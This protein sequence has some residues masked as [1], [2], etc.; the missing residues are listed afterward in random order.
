MLLSHCPLSIVSSSSS[1]SLF[2][3]APSWRTKGPWEHLPLMAPTAS[4]IDEMDRH[5]LGSTG[6]LLSSV[7]LSPYMYNSD[8]AVLQWSV[9]SSF[10]GRCL[11]LLW[12]CAYI[13][14]LTFL[15]EL[16][17]IYLL[18]LTLGYFTIKVLQNRRL[19]VNGPFSL[20]KPQT[21]LWKCNWIYYVW[22]ITFTFKTDTTGVGWESLFEA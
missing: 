10:K 18:L 1:S 12:A 7:V 4:H 3:Q 11:S 15:N 5:T 16:S 22:S 17:P 20:S 2:I 21:H 9:L 19:I 14:N 13:I 6:S 8:K